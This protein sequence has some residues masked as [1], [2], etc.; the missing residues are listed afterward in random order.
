VVRFCSPTASVSDD[1]GKLAAASEKDSE[2]LRALIDGRWDKSRSFREEIEERIR[3]HAGHGK[4]RFGPFHSVARPPN[5]S[6]LHLLKTF[7]LGFQGLRNFPAEFR[8]AILSAGMSEWSA[9]ALVDLQRL[10]REGKASLLTDDV[11]RL[12]GRKPITF[13]QFARDY[14]FAF[15]TELKAAS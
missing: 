8:K 6:R 7:H 10:Y 13:D 14:A 2:M 1:R 11:E 4:E 15:Q 5:L 12:T 3:R 9:D